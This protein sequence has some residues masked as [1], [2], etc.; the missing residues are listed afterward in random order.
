MGNPVSESLKT[1][2]GKTLKIF[3]VKTEDF[4]IA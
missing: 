1:E 3:I 4:K 2:D